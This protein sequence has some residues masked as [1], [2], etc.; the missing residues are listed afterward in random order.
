MALSILL[1]EDDQRFADRLCQFLRKE[2][3][4]VEHAPTGEAGVELVQRGAP[5]LVL[6]DLVLPGIDG[7]ETLQRI[8]E[9]SDAVAVIVLTA[10]ASVA[11]AVEAMRLGAQDY[12]TKPLDLDAL[13]AKL[14]KVQ[15]LL[16]LQSDLEYV[17]DREQRGAGFENFV[18]SCPQMRAAFERMREVAKTDNTTVLVTGESGTGKELVAQAIHSL[19]ARRKKPRYSS[20]PCC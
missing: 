14:G 15:E 18:G 19:S 10:H 9:V 16:G 12:M 11:T 8:R 13:C 20:T 5:D 3:H 17:L 4:D 7:V 2:E 6:L 1:I